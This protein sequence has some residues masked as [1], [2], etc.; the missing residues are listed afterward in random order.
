MLNAC[1]VN[2]KRYQIYNLHFFIS[3]TYE[4]IHTVQF[5]EAM[6]EIQQRKIFKESKKKV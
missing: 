1:V 2:L 4:Q 3:G 6:D 5:D